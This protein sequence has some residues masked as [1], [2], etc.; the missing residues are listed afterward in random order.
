MHSLSSSISS[1]DMFVFDSSSISE[2]LV[3]F[4]VDIGVVTGRGV[5]VPVSLGVVTDWV[6]GFV[7]VT[8]G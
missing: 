4:E 6:N 3:G 5:D 1:S 8:D 7:T 2:G